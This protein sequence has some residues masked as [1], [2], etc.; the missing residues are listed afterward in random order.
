SLWLLL[1]STLLLSSCTTFDPM[2]REAKTSNATVGVGLGAMG[3]ALIGAM[4]GHSS[5]GALIGAGIG[6]LAG[7]AVG[8]YMDQQ[9]AMLRAQLESTGVQIVRTSEDSIQLIM[10]CDITF[11]N[12]SAT[13]RDDFFETLNSVAIVLKRYNRTLVNVAGFTSN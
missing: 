11:A 10:P 12:D 4:S 13:L 9:E 8:S 5:K 6:A 7:G 1:V 3:G 2:T